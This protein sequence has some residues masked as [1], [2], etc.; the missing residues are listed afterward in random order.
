[1]NL[2]TTGQQTSKLVNPL[3]IIKP[4]WEVS[5]KSVNLGSLIAKHDIEPPDEIVFPPTTHHMLLVQLTRGD[6]QLTR[7]GSKEYSGIFSSG[8][9]V[10]H[11]A[12]I[13]ALYSWSTTDEAVIFILEPDFLTRLARETEV[14]Y[15]EKIE[16]KPILCDRDA[17]IE[18]IARCFLH[19]MQT[20]GLGGRL[21]SE[22]LATQLGIHLLRNYSVLP[23][24][25]KQYR[26]GLSPSKLQV[27]I[28]YIQANLEYKIGLDDLAKVTKISP[29]HFSRLFKQSTGLTPYQYVI[30]QRIE[31]GKQLL[32]QENLSIS[33]I[34]LICGFANQSSFTSAFGKFVGVTPRIYRKQQF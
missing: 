1:M 16:L 13:P 8:E 4:E 2:E 23:I 34:S 32:G 6:E 18:Y 11:P 24:K 7:I 26:G 21:Y 3:D 30:Q 27:A 28:N 5:R 10:L 29:Y 25:P 22:A 20:E 17:H 33:E 31:L 15:P 14:L 12:N 9:F 19:E